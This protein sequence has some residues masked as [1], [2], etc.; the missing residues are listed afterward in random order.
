MEQKFQYQPVHSACNLG[1][2]LG[3]RHVVEREIPPM[4]V[5]QLIEYW[6]YPVGKCSAV[7]L[8]LT[9]LPDFHLDRIVDIR[10]E[11]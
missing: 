9:Q 8:Q 4:T 1:A 7:Q 5:P 11:N 10:I 2:A 3:S 6:G